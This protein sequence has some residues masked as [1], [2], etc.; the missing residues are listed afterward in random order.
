MKLKH[1]LIYSVL[2]VFI[3]SCS[4]TGDNF[5]T[6]VVPVDTA[7]T[8]TPAAP[9]TIAIGAD[10]PP[11]TGD[12]SNTLFGNPSG[13]A[14][15]VV[16]NKDNYYINQGYYAESYNSTKEEPNWV[17]WHLDASNITSAAGRQDSFA[18][19]AGLPTS[20]AAVQSNSYVYAT[21]GFDRGHNC[22][23]ADRSSS[24]NANNATFL[25]TNMIPQ[26]PANNQQT[27]GNLENYIR[28]LVNAGNEIYII[29]G[30]Y[31]TGGTGIHGAWN[32][33]GPL[34]VN[35]PSN[36]WKIAVVL[37]VGNS[38]ITRV[39]ASTRVI[40]VN[41][42]NIQT[43]SSDWKQYI[44]TVRDIEAATGYNLLSALP[45]NIQDAVETKK[46]PGI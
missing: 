4:K 35:V 6:T 11:A 18:P 36:V 3:V 20:F 40:A 2:S 15:D 25:M 9:V 37:P 33:I 1:L 16:L 13:A 14:T 22:P 42:P 17:S 24:V 12:N 43:I 32:K 45:Q 23:S 21:Y 27:W 44:V 39:T 7:G 30:S 46:D 10:A 29:M 8:S 5:T 26:A 41:T 34:N 38:D 19:F 28:S 31:G